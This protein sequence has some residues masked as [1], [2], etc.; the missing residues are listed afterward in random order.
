VTQRRVAEGLQDAHTAVR[1]RATGTDLGQARAW[2]SSALLW[3]WF[4]VLA[5]LVAGPLLGSGHLLLLDFPSGPRFPDF[6]FLPLPSSGDVGNTIPTAAVHSVLRSIHP[7]LPEKLF[8]LAPIVLGGA[9][10][11]RLVRRRLSLGMLPAAY[12]GTLFAVNPFVYDRYTAGHLYLLLAY[13]LL[14]W[15]FGSLIVAM[16]RRDGRSA[17]VVAAWIAGLAAIDLHIAGMFAMLVIAGALVGHRRGDLVAGAVAI[18]VATLLAAY[19]LLPGLFVTPGPRIGAADLTVY[20][21]RPSG[22]AVFPRLLGLQ[23]FWRDEFAGAT[24]RIPPLALLLV[25]ILFLA[26]AG[27]RNLLASERESR[28]TRTLAIGC[29][30]AIVLA[31]A[32]AFSPTASLFRWL[33]ERVPGLGIYREPQKLV[34][35]VALALAVWGAVGLQRAFDAAERRRWWPRTRFARPLIAALMMAVALAYAYPILWGLWGQVSLSRYPDGWTVVERVMNETGPGR[36]L[37]LPWHLYGVW[38]FTDG[39][40]VANPAPSFFDREVLS[41]DEAGFLEV[42]PQSPDPFSPY[43]ESILEHRGEIRA[44]GHLVA[45]LDVRYIALLREIDWNGYGFLGHQKDLGELYRDERIMLLEN[46]AWSGDLLRLSSFESTEHP[47]DLFGTPREEQVTDRLFRIPAL[48][49]RS[50]ASIPGIA[51]PLPI[52]REIEPSGG[53]FIATATRC[54]DGWLLGRQS[55]QC[56]LGTVSAFESPADRKPLWRPMTGL[57]LSGV[58]ISCLTL[59]GLLLYRRGRPPAIGT[60]RGA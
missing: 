5:L 40:I 39:R 41:A 30:V 16:E 55:A 35:I 42:P 57:W 45:P 50:D 24:E 43:I 4:V 32:T 44:F 9:G 25:P 48:A 47:S 31:G 49:P 12:A 54:T 38:S 10:A 26:L 53:P 11:A 2:V 15:A 13:A 20:A 28:W 21:S 17:V 19:W 18:G 34:A 52:W 22:I 51:E 3:A 60:A 36:V 37:V 7:L 6:S 1:P 14:P 58:A 27:V 33:L 23:G 29:V 59:L 56:M 8:L 46:R